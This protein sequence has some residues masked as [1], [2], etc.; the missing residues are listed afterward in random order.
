MSEPWAYIAHKDG[1]LG[2]MIAGD[3]DKKNL[4]NFLGDFAADG[5]SI[6]T[7]SSRPEY[8]AFIKDKKFCGQPAL[9]TAQGKT[10]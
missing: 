8:L 10:E 7:V 5:F 4:K 3:A 2:G 9:K 1:M 6:Q